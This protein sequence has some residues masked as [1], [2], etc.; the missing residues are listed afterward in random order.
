MSPFHGTQIF[1]LQLHFNISVSFSSL[2]CDQILIPFYAG[3]TWQRERDF[4]WSYTINQKKLWTHNQELLL[5]FASSSMSMP[6]FIIIYKKSIG[7]PEQNFPWILGANR[8]NGTVSSDAG[9]HIQW[10][11]EYTL[12]SGR[13]RLTHQLYQW[14]VVWLWA[15]NLLNL[16]FCIHTSGVLKHTLWTW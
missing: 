1:S 4:T 5:L 15:N 6:Q 11:R 14:Q 7:F 8:R 10:L 16:G 13:P 12:E 3:N 2:L 9:Q